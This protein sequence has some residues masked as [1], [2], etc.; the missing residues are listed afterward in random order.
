MWWYF[1]ACGF[2]EICLHPVDLLTSFKVH[3]VRVEVRVVSQLR[4]M[5]MTFYLC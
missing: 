2:K 3:F 5:M 1:K 4:L